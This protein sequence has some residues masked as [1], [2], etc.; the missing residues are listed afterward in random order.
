MKKEEK[1]EGCDQ[2]KNAT[3]HRFSCTVYGKKTMSLPVNYKEKEEK[4]EE[5]SPTSK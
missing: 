1:C 3:K 2:P 5:T 4:S